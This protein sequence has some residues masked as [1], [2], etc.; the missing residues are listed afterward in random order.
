MKKMNRKQM[1][2][3]HIRLWT[4]LSKNPDKEKVQWPG[5][6]RIEQGV[7]M[8]CF[9]CLAAFQSDEGCLMACPIKWTG[10]RGCGNGE[11]GR[12]NYMPPSKKRAALALKIAGMWPEEK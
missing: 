11:F 6:G 8:G 7:P 3:E 9:A 2:R 10:G 1:R 12:W 4:W 5:W